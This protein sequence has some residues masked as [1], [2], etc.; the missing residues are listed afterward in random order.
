MTRYSFELAT[1]GD[2]G[3]IS[4][5]L[6]RAPMAGNVALSF[7]KE[8]DYFT[9]VRTEGLF[10]QTI[11]T[12]DQT[13]QHIVAVASRSIKPAYVNGRVEPLGYLG[14]LR[15]S[16]EHRNRFILAHGYGFLKRLHA[17]KRTPFY[18]TTIMDDNKT[19]KDILTSGR[20][21]LP[22]YHDCGLLH[23]YA[24]SKVKRSD[25]PGGTLSVRRATA[26]DADQVLDILCREG[27]QKQFF[28]YITKDQL[29][30]P[31][32][33]L[34]DITIRDFFVAFLDNQPAGVCAF[35]DQ[36]AFKQILVH[37]YRGRMKAVRPL[38]NI[39]ASL[40]G[41]PRLPSAGR[42]LK[43]LYMSFVAVQDNNPAVFRA[44]LSAG[45]QQHADTKTGLILVGLHERD[46]LN[47]VL[48]GNPYLRFNS[49][50]F[51]ASW[52]DGEHAFRRLDPRVPYVE[53]ASL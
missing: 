43:V 13:R 32:A 8:P 39:W 41:R 31:N 40:G 4:A 22:A 53:I 5:L 9:A 16:P 21:G 25:T 42:P 15:I 38:Y 18:L 33:Y 20:A 37:A 14:G 3:Q 30:E 2:Q 48:K 24:L 29:L 10:T 36:R 11:V 49:R 35:W 34:R 19:A 47:A 52:E 17:D 50:L 23:T 1:E 44:L 28:P 46:P 45:F 51:V 7:K 27:G 6:N 26:E 12:R